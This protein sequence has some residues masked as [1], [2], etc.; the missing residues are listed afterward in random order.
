MDLALAM[1][2]DDIGRDAALTIAR[3]LVLFLRRPGNQSQFSM[4]LSAQLAQ[5]SSLRDLQQWALE[6]PDADL[7]VEALAARAAI[8]P[9]HFS[10]SFREEVGITP[11][12]YVERI[13]LE[14]ARRR[15][16]DDR[17]PIAL[18]AAACG[19]G[20]AETMRRTFLRA[21]GVSPAE[22]RRRFLSAA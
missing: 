2:E 8:S 20:T 22:Y 3:H 16:E 1:V 6:H 7:S 12:R 21:L 5:R 14:A 13:R 11:G 19:F 17:E 10:R 15:L 9:R 4:Q 18:V